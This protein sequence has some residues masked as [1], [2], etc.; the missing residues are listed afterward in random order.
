MRQFICAIS[1]VVLFLSLTAC[2]P[3]AYEIAHVEP[4]VIS[5]DSTIIADE[6]VAELI[7]PYTEKL[8]TEMEVV[9]A[10]C[11]QEIFKGKPESLLGNWMADLVLEK[12]RRYYNGNIDFSVVNFG[13][14]RV[15]S[16]PQGNITRGKIYELMPFDNYLVVVT[17]DGQTVQKLFDH[18]AN[19]GGWPISGAQF[20]LSSSKALGLHIGG[21]PVKHQETYRVA[22]SDYLANGGDKCTMLIDRPQ[23]PLGVLLRDAILEYCNELTARGELISP[24]LE[25]RI[26][27]NDQ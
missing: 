7:R 2:A 27:G 25:E 20:T 22:I 24:V 18:I 3:V 15:P 14:I 11:E 23:E 19:L 16:L 4:Q 8:S 21:Y 6:A 17:L 26:I 9:V 12:S 1:P 10:Q 13:G 5:L